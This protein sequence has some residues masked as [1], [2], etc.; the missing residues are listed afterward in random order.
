LSFYFR[1]P[2]ASGRLRTRLT[3]RRAP[4][5]KNYGQNIRHLLT[6]FFYQ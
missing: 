4:A 1:L 6:N 3:S 2:L 5:D